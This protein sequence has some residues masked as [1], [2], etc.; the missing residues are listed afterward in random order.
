MAA[1]CLPPRSWDSCLVAGGVNAVD[2]KGAPARLAAWRE[3]ISHLETLGQA[4]LFQLADAAL[5]R[6]QLGIDLWRQHACHDARLLG[7]HLQVAQ[8]PGQGRRLV[9]PGKP[10]ANRGELVLCGQ[11]LS[12]DRAW[13][14]GYPSQLDAK[15][16]PLALERSSQLI[17]RHPRPAHVV[18]RDVTLV[19]DGDAFEGQ[20]AY[21]RSQ[22]RSLDWRR[23]SPPSE[24]K[25]D[26]SFSDALQNLLAKEHLKGQSYE[27]DQA[28]RQLI[29]ALFRQR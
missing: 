10:R 21:R 19:D 24:G 8:R 5:E 11:S 20:D 3:S 14:I 17:Q 12:Q 13:V 22:R 6:Q 15:Q 1:R 7:N 2:R 9:E 29:T 4:N 25:R 18:G 27:Y 28:V 23:P 26:A 16:R